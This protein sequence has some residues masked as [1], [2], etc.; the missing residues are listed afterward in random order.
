M[1]SK[2]VYTIFAFIFIFM[3]IWVYFIRDNGEEETSEDDIPTELGFIDLVE[4]WAED[5]VSSS[6]NIE[7]TENPEDY[8]VDYTFNEDEKL[9]KID[10]VKN[11]VIIGTK[12]LEA[13]TSL[14]VYNTALIDDK[15]I[16]FELRGQYST[17]CEEV[18]VEL[19]EDCELEEDVIEEHGG[20][21]IYTIGSNNKFEKIIGFEIKE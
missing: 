9:F 14:K 2:T 19:Q 4:V 12:E 8:T 7:I 15:Y 16:A 13:E 11:S 3:A 18:Q 6:S 21:W 20:I 17:D 5:T 10:T 1:K